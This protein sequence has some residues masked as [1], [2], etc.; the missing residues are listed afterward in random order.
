MINIM[1]IGLYPPPKLKQLVDKYL[2]KDKPDYPDFL[3]KIYNWGTPPVDGKYR[4]ITIY[5][6]PEDKL[7]DALLALTK[8]YKFYAQIEGYTFEILPLMSEAEA[9]KIA[10]G[11]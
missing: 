6:C 9:M 10:L 8:R 5:E 2:Q 1:T 7:H 11:K 4:T 3:K